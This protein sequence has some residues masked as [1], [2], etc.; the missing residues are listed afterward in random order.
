MTSAPRLI[1][2]PPPKAAWEGPR[3]IWDVDAGSVL[4]AV[5]VLV[6]NHELL[7]LFR[8]LEG[9][10]RRSCRDDV[11]LRETVRLCG[12]RGA[13]A[14][15]VERLLDARTKG[16]RRSVAESP[17]AVLAASW[18][19]SR[20]MIDGRALTALLWNLAR[21]RRFVVRPLRE[22]VPGELWVRALR[23]LATPL[24]NEKEPRIQRSDA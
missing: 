9:E 6:E 15:A 21:D 8:S 18:L 14:E 10:D 7:D 16:L 3:R 12:R 24:P 20:D 17:L 5:G 2:I 13:F 19:G 11:L 22:M 1:P 23:L 4:V